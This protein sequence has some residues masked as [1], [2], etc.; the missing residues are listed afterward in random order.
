MTPLG[1]GDYRFRDRG[2]DGTTVE[3]TFGGS[4][5]EH[6][7]I[8]EGETVTLEYVYRAPQELGSYEHGGHTFLSWVPSGYPANGG[9]L[10]GAQP[11]LP[12]QLGEIADRAV[13]ALEG[14]QRA[15]IGDH[16]TQLWVYDAKLY[17]QV[18]GGQNVTQG[19]KITLR[20]E[21]VGDSAQTDVHALTDVMPA[22]FVL[23]S[24]V[25]TAP[26]GTATPLNADQYYTEE[27]DSE[28]NGRVQDAR[29]DF[30]TNGIGRVNVGTGKMSV[31]FTYIAPEETG[32]KQTGGGMEISGAGGAFYRTTK[33]DTGA[34]SVNVVARPPDHPDPRPAG[35]RQQLLR[36][37]RLGLAEL[38][39]F[40]LRRQIAVRWA[41]QSKPADALPPDTGA[42]M[43]KFTRAAAA[44]TIAAA[45]AVGVASPATAQVNPVLP[46]FGSLMPGMGESAAEK[47][48]L[49][50]TGGWI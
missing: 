23:D 12:G 34:P 42:T 27:R 45:M 43:K 32:W 24:V 3:V 5:N 49:G 4:P 11:A 46:D 48:K 18:M 40:Q 1:S 30:A 35:R 9:V 15:Q 33:V 10:T 37:H 38:R 7:Q 41:S 26:D 2:A 31:D 14:G 16:L 28:T 8:R 25:Y 20:V 22:G 13:S 29:V 17:K 39:F 47:V 36:L 21:V 6:P 44:A 50:E 19:E